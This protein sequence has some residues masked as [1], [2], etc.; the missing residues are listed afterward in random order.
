MTIGNDLDTLRRITQ[1]LLDPAAELCAL[2]DAAV[3]M[4]ALFSRICELEGSLPSSEDSRE[5]LLATGKAISPLDAGRCV[6]DFARTAKFLRGVR[7]A[8]GEAQS[9]FPGETTHVLYAGTYHV[10]QRFTT[11]AKSHPCTSW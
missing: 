11:T 1:T 8:I 6:L 7:A 2:R 9:R 10:M 3:E 4:H 5:T